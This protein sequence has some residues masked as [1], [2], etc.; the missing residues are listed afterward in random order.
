MWSSAYSPR[1]PPL[2]LPSKSSTSF[3]KK[4]L[5]LSRKISKRFS[6]GAPQKDQTDLNQVIAR[7]PTDLYSAGTVLKTF[8]GAFFAKKTHH[9][10]GDGR[11]N[12][13]SQGCLYSS[14]DTVA[15]SGSTSYCVYIGGLGF[16]NG[17]S[18]TV[19]CGV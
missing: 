10:F 18:Y 15:G 8:L 17:C 13:V 16:N 19:K 4:Y 2:D 6:R 11:F 7:F 14:D 12:L 9:L 1:Y 3:H 5:S